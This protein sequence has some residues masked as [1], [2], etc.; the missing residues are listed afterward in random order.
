MEGGALRT[1]FTIYYI[2]RYYFRYKIQWSKFILEDRI[3][4]FPVSPPPKIHFF[5]ALEQWSKLGFRR[6]IRHYKDN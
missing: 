5:V 6:E 2:Q 3:W 4:F 1:K